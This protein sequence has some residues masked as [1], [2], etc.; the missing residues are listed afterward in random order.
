MLVDATPPAVPAPTLTAAVTYSSDPVFVDGETVTLHDLAT[1]SGSG[2]GDVEYYFCA[3]AASACTSTESSTLI[4]RSTGA[5]DYP[6][7]WDTSAVAGGDYRVIAVAS[8]GSANEA[9]SPGV[10]VS[11]DRTAPTASAPT[12]DGKS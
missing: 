1:D 11:V 4:G 10:L 12:V 2:I 8:D 6:V 9:T 3:A 5:P 7:A